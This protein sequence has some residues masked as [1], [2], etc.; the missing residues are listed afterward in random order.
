MF[1]LF[2]RNIFFTII[3]PGLVAGLFPFWILGDKAYKELAE[4]LKLQKY[5]AIV[6]FLI[7][8]TILLSCIIRFAVEGRGTLS[9]ADPTKR[10]VIKGFYKYSRNPMYVGVILILIGESIF[11]SS[12]NLLLYSL[13]IFICF[14]IFIIFIEEPRL[15]RDF[16]SEYLNYCKQAR[17]WI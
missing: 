4:S 9:P 13:F 17:R 12:G 2:L 8:L 7:G 16:T 15:K 10:L 11:F 6:I 5:I 14:N 3:H 1:S